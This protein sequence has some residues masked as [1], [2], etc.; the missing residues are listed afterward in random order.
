MKNIEAECLYTITLPKPRESPENCQDACS[1]NIESQ[2]FSISDGVTKSFL[3]ADWAK[4]LVE[5]FT[6]NNDESLDTLFSSQDWQTWLAPLQKQWE[7]QAKETVRK[8]T[9]VKSLFLRNQLAER[10]PAAATF[11]GLRK[12]P[13]GGNK[14]QYM[15]IGDSCLFHFSKRT[16][17]ISSYL[18]KSFAEFSSH[19]G[20]LASYLDKS[21]AEPTFGEISIEEGDYVL[22]CTDALSK[23]LFYFR[24]NDI[25]TF[26]QSAINLL[27]TNNDIENHIEVFRLNKDFPLEGDD[28]GIVALA[29]KEF[30]NRNPA[31]S[32]PHQ[33]N[34]TDL[35]SAQTQSTR[36]AKTP[37]P[38][39]KDSSTNYESKQSTEFPKSNKILSLSVYI[40]AAILIV[41]LT[42]V[43]I[44]H[45]N[46][47]S[48]QNITLSAEDLIVLSPSSPYTL[49][50]I[51]NDFTVTIIEEQIIEG[52][53]WKKVEYSGWVKCS[54]IPNR[55][56]LFKSDTSLLVYSSPTDQVSVGIIPQGNPVVVINQ[57]VVNS[58]IWCH[59]ISQ[60]Y[61]T[62]EE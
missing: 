38:P 22:L 25:K 8:L 45:Y 60:G 29:F 7:K 10:I 1:V 33:I 14:W 44:R 51:T 34:H 42:T 30:T 9:D 28:V 37:E 16:Q 19:P 46:K 59:T 61:I 50:E 62:V 4:L 53:V 40:L 43:T 58:D 11:I 35:Q 13:G 23:F 20:S 41:I 18:L 15:I 52:V 39:R 48:V 3:P 12:K 36:E 32:I 27:G 31:A 21:N 2:R 5:A 17:N 57:S 54:S 47:L 6:S 56:G 55:I 49:I 26:G 24:E